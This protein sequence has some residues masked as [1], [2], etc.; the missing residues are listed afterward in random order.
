MSEPPSPSVYDAL[1]ARPGIRRAVA[2][3]SARITADPALAGYFAGVDLDA[4]RAHQVDLLVATL[5]GPRR[6]T[7]R[8]MATAHAGLH[9]TDAD[10]DRMLG[11]LNAALVD[12][13][14]DDGTIRAVII[15]VSGLRT[16]IVGA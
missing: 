1:G 9:I 12:V 10:F 4:V 2:G 14:A 16:A 6:Y 8:D 15:S 13:G 11:H 7:G 3:F 5:G